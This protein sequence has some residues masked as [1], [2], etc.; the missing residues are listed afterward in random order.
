MRL[1]LLFFVCTLTAAGQNLKSG[2][3]LKPEQAIMDIRHYTISL[4][5]DPVTKSI[6][7]YTE[8]EIRF[9]EKAS[10]ILLDFWHGL[11]VSQVQ[12]NGRMRPFTHG[13]DDMLRIDQLLDPG[14]ATVRVDY[15]GKPGIAER[16]PW[17]GG[18]QFEKDSKGN[19]WI[20]ITCQSE[21]GKIFFPCKDH[22]SD[23]PDEGADL[24]ITVPKGL[25]A[26]GPGL[27]INQSTSGKKT[28]FHWRTQYP[29]SNYSLV[30]N[31]GKFRKVS[32]PYTTVEGNRVPM[33]FY[34][35]EEHAGKAPH[36]LEMLDRTVRILE[37]YFG[38]Y[39][40]VKEKIG[41]CE[42]PHLGM[43]H[44]T[45]NAYGN[46]FRYTTVGGEDFDWLLNH[47]FGHEWWGNKVSNKDWAHMWIQE[48][49]CSFGDA[50]YIREMEGEESYRLRM[51]D[52]ARKTEN[53]LP[54]VQGEVLDSDQSY[55]GDIYGKG[56]FFMHT[57]RY[58]MGDDL[59][60]PALKKLAMDPQFHSITTDDV[61]TLFS[62]AYGGNLKPLFDL[63]LRTTEKMV[64]SMYQ[65]GAST[66]EIELENLNMEIPLEV[67][68]D[69]GS[70]RLMVGKTPVEIKSTTMPVI[71]PKIFY[72]KVVIIE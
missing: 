4:D 33:D 53:K 55:H 31:I 24:I 69:A 58:V 62:Q 44:Q 7:G 19:P 22:P 35:L 67:V 26:A 66:Y 46:Q 11:K 48:G 8:I 10:V 52:I 21:G 25:V 42:T 18:F 27:L 1:L 63:F 12:V 70:N 32:R 23:K 65:T 34:V 17:T 50:L 39:P 2:G 6:Y 37:K 57:L 28:T 38:E 72:L 51:G 71:D 45:L 40:W 15:G 54:V 68:T 3:P 29:I 47:E 43:E 14:T 56:A 60:F 20:A 16:A 41:L 59:F 64:V 5:V 9:T 13:A 30:F 61:E 49:I 36:L